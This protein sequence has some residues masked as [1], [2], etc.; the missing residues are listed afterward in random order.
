MTGTESFFIR[1]SGC[2]LRCWFCDTPYASWD[3]KGDTMTINA[4]I[5]AV[6]QSGLKHVVLTGGEP[7]VP[8]ESSDLCRELRRQEIHVTIETA[9]TV[10][11]HV[12]CDLL[13]I[14]PKFASSA[15]DAVNHPQWNRLHER[16][17]MP[18]EKMRAL[19]QRSNDY[20]LKFV[21]DSAADYDELTLVVNQLRA[22]SSDVWVMPQG[23]T[24][25][26]M[27]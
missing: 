18:I 3:P 9:G 10:D 26:A 7:L 21:V 14:S 16:R 25:E 27:D 19:I 4:I 15:P 1:T 13:S 12:E 17:R 6:L 11:R 22:D 24:I 5:D 20:Q 23:S 2:N 8:R